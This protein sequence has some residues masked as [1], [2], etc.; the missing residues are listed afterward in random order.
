MIILSPIKR[1][2]VYVVLFEILAIF[3]STLVL[4]V[5]SGSN[6]KGSLPVAII[7]ST[8][9]VVW[10]YIYNSGFEYWEV[11]QDVKQRTLVIRIV[12]ASGF[13]AGLVMICLPLYMIWYDVD[14]WTA[15]SMELT[16][17]V[18]FLVY[19]F[20]FTLLFDQVFTLHHKNNQSA[21]LNISQA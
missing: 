21:D 17:L 15:L 1:R 16:L 12:H 3:L 14:V 10:N 13:E 18:F 7:M 11:R 20:L 2:F 5:L 6:V 9:A 19:T 8:T 4:M